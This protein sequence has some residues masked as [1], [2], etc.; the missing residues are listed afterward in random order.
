MCI[1]ALHREESCGGHFR[2]EYQ[3]EDGEALRDDDE[4]AYVAAWEYAGEGK[5][6]VLHKEP[7]DFEYVHPSQRSYK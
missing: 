5:P 6:P 4:F 1:D 7:L 3:T 2:A